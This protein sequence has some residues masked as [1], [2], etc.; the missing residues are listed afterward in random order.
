LNTDNRK[1]SSLP[2]IFRVV[3]PYRFIGSGFW[4]TLGWAMRNNNI[5]DP[6]TSGSS[7]LIEMS[8]TLCGCFFLIVL[9]FLYRRIGSISRHPLLE[10]GGYV[11][12]IIA[13]I[14][15]WLMIQGVISSGSAAL[16]ARAILGGFGNTV[17]ALAW[18]EVYSRLGMSRVFLYGSLSLVLAAVTVGIIENLNAPFDTITMFV[19]VLLSFPLCYQSIHYVG[20]ET[21]SN[22]ENIR[23]PFPYIPL[24]IMIVAKLM[25]NFFSY[26][27]LVRSVDLHMPSILIFGIFFLMILIIFGSRIKPVTLLGIAF[28]SIAIGLVGVAFLGIEQ[29]IYP[30]VLIRIGYTAIGF[31]VFSMLANISYRHSVP[32]IW[33]FGLAIAVRDIAGQFSRLIAIA[34]PDLAATLR[35]SPFHVAISSVIGLVLLGMLA[36][37]WRMD[38]DTHS[39]WALHGIDVKSGQISPSDREILVERCQAAAKKYLL[40]EREQE[41]MIALFEGRSYSEIGSEFFLS[42]NTVKTHMRH[43]YTKLNAHNRDEAKSII[44]RLR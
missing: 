13:A 28:V 24:I 25:T 1:L 27:T 5:L 39:S 32:S 9:A 36:L 3:I 11:S 12:L 19:V 30:A 42:V 10:G 4:I 16:W 40:T 18:A 15:S 2:E 35:T 14:L 6:G 31:F 17:L 29:N 21:I 38:F 41:I 26:T 33:L 20:S 37:L 8:L 43:I 44:E 23:F 22:L 7:L 34:A